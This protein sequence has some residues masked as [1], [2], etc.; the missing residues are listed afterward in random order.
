M[1]HVQFITNESERYS[2]EQSAA[3]ALKGGCKWIQLRMKDYTQDERKNVALKVSKLCKEYKAIFIIDDDVELAKE[4]EADG[5]HLGKKDMPINQARQIL[6]Q[7]MII[8]AT[9]NK[10]EDIIIAKQMGA[11]YIGLG[12]FRFTKTKKELSP[13]I[14]IEGYREIMKQ[15][16]QSEIKIPVVAIGGISKEDVPA[17]MNTGINGI[18]ISG[19]ILQAEDGEKEMRSFLNITTE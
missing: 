8:G 7:G 17:L 19:A 15:V 2:H 4:I 9:A 5:V 6:G 16:R 14:G 3:I 18:A 12:P 1:I 13:I 11:D 10:F